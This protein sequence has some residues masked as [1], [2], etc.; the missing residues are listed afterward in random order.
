MREHAR[1]G[2]V[3]ANWVSRVH[4]TIDPTTAEALA[5]ALIVVA[6]LFKI[7]GGAL[8]IVGAGLLLTP[9]SLHRRFGVWSIAR[10]SAY[11]R[12]A[13]LGSLVFGLFILYAALW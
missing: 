11:L 1:Q 8:A 2:G 12:P 4:S 10:M 9:P 13:G 6:G 7:F 5:Q 3:P